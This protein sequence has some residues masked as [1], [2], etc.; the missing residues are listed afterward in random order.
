MPSDEM[1]SATMQLVRPGG[2]PIDD[3]KLAA[4]CADGETSAFEEIYRRWG[5]R[6]KSVAF[7]HLGNTA[8]AED[9]VQETLLKISRSASAY[10]GEAP[11]SHW[12]FRILVNTCLD[13]I[14][15]RQRRHDSRHDTDEELLASTRA[16][17]VDELK[18][19][20]LR[21]LLDAL[22]DQKRSVFTLFEIE[23]FSHAEIASMLDI[24]EANSKWILFTTKKQLQQQWMET[25]VSR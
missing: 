12:A 5:K 25:Q 22:P 13:A 4:S 16:A 2:E 7:N 15:K 14:R 20:T 11:F 1:I 8:D 9:A 6:M 19:I 24:S 17:S 3:R 21:K 23:G 10:T 18:R